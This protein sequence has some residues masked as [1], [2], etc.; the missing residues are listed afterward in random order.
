MQRLLNETPQDF[1]ELN[2]TLPSCL[3]LTILSSKFLA[4]MKDFFGEAQIFN[5]MTVQILWLWTL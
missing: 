2:G 1:I 5:G 4:L 3:F